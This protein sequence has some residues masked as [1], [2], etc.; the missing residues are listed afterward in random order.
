MHWIQSTLL[1]VDCLSFRHLA[2]IFPVTNQDDGT[3]AVVR[4]LDIV[5][6]EVTR[7]LAACALLSGE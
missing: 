5:S 1:T 6:C 7:S 3:Y 2:I 4:E